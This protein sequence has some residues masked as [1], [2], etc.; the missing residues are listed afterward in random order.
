METRAESPKQEVLET[1]SFDI[2]GAPA[3]NVSSSQSP[4]CCLFP[5]RTLPAQGD[6]WEFTRCLR[7]NSSL[8]HRCK[9]ITEYTLIGSAG[10]GNKFT[11]NC[12]VRCMNCFH[13]KKAYY[14]PGKMMQIEVQD[15]CLLMPSYRMHCPAINFDEAFLRQRVVETYISR[16]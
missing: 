5:H 13:A 2:P 16:L 4:L 9:R 1:H 3:F 6:P 15:S 7:T 12:S 14:K 10:N 8:S 11:N